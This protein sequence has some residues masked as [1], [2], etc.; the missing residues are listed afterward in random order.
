MGHIGIHDVGDQ[1][2]GAR[3]L[4]QKPECR[5]EVKPDPRTLVLVIIE[6]AT[7]RLS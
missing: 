7:E 5:K 4:G 1:V 6:V 3:D 2:R